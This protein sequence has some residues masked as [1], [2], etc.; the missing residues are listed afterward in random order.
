MARPLNFSRQYTKTRLSLEDEEL[1]T[2]ILEERGITRSELAREL[3]NH[4]LEEIRLELRRFDHS[5]N[6]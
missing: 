5:Y 4:S 3:I 2:A 1:F 6:L